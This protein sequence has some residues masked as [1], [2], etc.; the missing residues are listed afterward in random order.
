M[1]FWHTCSMEYPL[2]NCVS[3]TKVGIVYVCSVNAYGDEHS[4]LYLYGEVLI[5][6][7]FLTNSSPYILRQGYFVGPGTHYLKT[8]AWLPSSGDPCLSYR[9]FQ[10]FLVFNPGLGIST[11]IFI[12]AWQALS[13]LSNLPRA[14]LIFIRPLFVCV[15]I[16]WHEY[17]LTIPTLLQHW[18]R[19]PQRLVKG[20]LLIGATSLHISTTCKLTFCSVKCNWI[21]EIIK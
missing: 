11:N 7:A 1:T 10:V 19:Y 18:S 21:S 5:L 15:C 13:S 4:P 14:S 6:F 12:C 3:W 8:S 20:E 17:N 2:V 16:L 9:C